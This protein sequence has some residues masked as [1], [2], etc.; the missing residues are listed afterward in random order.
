MICSFTFANRLATRQVKQPR[1]TTTTN[2]TNTNTKTKMLSSDIYIRGRVGPGRR[3]RVPGVGHAVVRERRV[4]FNLDEKYDW[5]SIKG[6]LFDID[7]TLCNT[8]PIHLVAIK[9]MFKRAGSEHVVDEDFIRNHISGVDNP[10][11]TRKLLPHLSEEEAK[12]WILDKEALF[13]ELAKDAIKPVDGL[14]ELVEWIKKKN[15]K[16]GA[17]TNAPRANAELI[18]EALGLKE[19]FDVVVAVDEARANKPSPEPYLRAM[20]LLNLK[21]RDCC[22]V[23]D[24]TTGATA[25][26]AAKV[27]T[28]GILTSQTEEAMKAV[29]VKQTIRNYNEL[30]D[31]IVKATTTTTT[32]K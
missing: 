20:T 14:L 28:I 2:T 15:I 27:H 19:K 17:V 13:R 5:K 18:L 25:A 4:G 16:L 26:V 12:Q 22:V 29:G 9:E 1:R 23:E 11:I 21:P 8:D 3:V 24:S 31:E 32:T 30:L 10:D 7:G 6:F